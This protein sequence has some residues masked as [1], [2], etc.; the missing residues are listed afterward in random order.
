MTVILDKPYNKQTLCV[1]KLTQ[2]SVSAICLFAH[3]SKKKTNSYYADAKESSR[4][5]VWLM[6]IPCN[7][8]SVSH[9]HQKEA[10]AKRE[11]NRRRVGTYLAFIT[12]FASYIYSALATQVTYCCNRPFA[13]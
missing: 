4:V 5:G 3:C 7:A 10:G 12:F 6:G 1:R 11:I 9:V 2:T 13:R 8:W